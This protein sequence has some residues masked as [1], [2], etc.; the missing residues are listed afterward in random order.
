MAA[1]ICAYSPIAACN[2]FA[3][4]WCLFAISIKAS[5]VA[6]GAPAACER[7]VEEQKVSAGSRIA[8]GYCA[9]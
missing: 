6:S 3:S 1:S 7:V 9:R 4:T 8:C 2:S 5:G